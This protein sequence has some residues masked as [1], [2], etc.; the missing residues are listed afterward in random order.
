VRTMHELRID[1]RDKLPELTVREEMRAR[2][3][4]FDPLVLSETEMEKYYDHIL[5]LRCHDVLLACDALQPW[6]YEEIDG[7]QVTMGLESELVA[8][9]DA[10]EE[11][12]YSDIDLALDDFPTEVHDCNRLLE[13][14]IAARTAKGLEDEDLFEYIWLMMSP[15]LTGRETHPTEEDWRRKQ[16]ELTLERAVETDDNRQSVRRHLEAWIRES[17]AKDREY[18]LSLLLGILAEANNATPAQ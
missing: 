1:I 18:T 4:G 15:F 17:L 6:L 9:L 5:P 16:A 11:Q 2:D 14:I 13:P 8:W 10:D 3:L 7:E 12:I